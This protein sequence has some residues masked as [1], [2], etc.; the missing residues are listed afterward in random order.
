MTEDINLGDG[1]MRYAYFR[2]GDIKH[3]T[4]VVSYGRLGCPLTRSGLIIRRH[5][6][7]IGYF[8]DS[9]ARGCP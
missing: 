2:C 8:V 9:W 5:G 3:D 1:G 7:P 4:K 6:F